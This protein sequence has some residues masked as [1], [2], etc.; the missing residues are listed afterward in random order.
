MPLDQKEEFSRYVYEIA[1]VQRQLVSDRIEVLARHHRHAWHYFIGCVTFSASS[2]MLMFKFWGPRHI[3]KN[4]MYY[5][6][7]LPPAISMGVA[8][9]GVIFTCR[10]MLMRNRICNMMEDYEYELKRINAHHCEVGIA[11]LA[12]LQFV[13]DQLKQ[14]AE[15]RFDFKKLREI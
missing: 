1:R 3:F 10:G 11:Q 8:L 4:S 15:Y 14:G 9:Y 5:A 7:P 2:V 6:R 12:W 13:T